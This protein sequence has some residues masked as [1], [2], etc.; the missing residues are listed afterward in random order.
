MFSQTVI[1]QALPASIPGTDVDPQIVVKPEKGFDFASIVIVPPGTSSANVVASV[2]AKYE[3]PARP[4]TSPAVGGD[5]RR[6]SSFQAAIRIKKSDSDTGGPVTIASGAS[7]P[8]VI[9][10]P[11][12]AGAS[13]VGIRLK[14]AGAAQAGFR[15]SVI[16]VPSDAHALT[17]DALRA[18]LSVS[19]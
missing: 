5:V 4:S 17:L 10:V 1:N 2:L 13:E 16:G 7:A 15:Y 11:L 19:S 3:L 9:L 14:S 18:Y 8:A 6:F 12:T